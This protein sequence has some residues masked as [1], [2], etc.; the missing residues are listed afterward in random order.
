MSH[1]AGATRR[2]VRRRALGLGLAVLLAGGSLAAC[3]SSS[4]SGGSGSGGD[5]DTGTLTVWQN[6]PMEEGG[7]G[8]MTQ[9]AKQ[10]E[11]AHPGAKIQFVTKPADNY[12]AILRAALIGHTGPDVA[13]IYPGTYVNGLTSNFLNLNPYIPVS[14]RTSIPGV[15]YFSETGDPNTNTYAM[16][17][18]NLFYNMWYN[19][20]LF[21]EAGVDSP[22]TDFVEMAHDCALFNAKGIT[23]YVDGNP[24]F[25]TPYAGAVSDWS[26]LVSAVY[27]LSD[28]NGLTEG[29]IPYNSPALVKEIEQWAGLFNAGCATKS[30][31]TQDANKEFSSGKAAMVMNYNGLY[32]TYSKA[33]GNNLGVMVP[34]WS[35]TPAH[36]LV[37]YPGFGYVASKYTSHPKLA[38]DFIAYTVSQ[39]AQELVAADN[40]LPIN[41]NV[42]ARG[43]ANQDLL[44][45]AEGGKY[46]LYPMF[47]NYMPPEVIAQITSQLPQAF[48]GS[49]SASSAL[50]TM[51]SADKALPSD[52]QHV[53]FH[54]GG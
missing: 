13:E 51:E 33:L 28:L 2:K 23:P 53:N 34:P 24:T 21:A 25:V 7:L 14:V 38:A 49:K 27:S 32:P 48:V 31:L 44:A 30:I 22:P 47:D 35:A 11:A 41:P 26:Y 42:Q 37:E 36:T 40:Q 54:L 45:M 5:G 50:D 15:K 9:V 19:K 6:G 4:S 52:E 17:P 8:F 46:D 3:G 10:F 29:S 12:F 18:V 39:P 1:V 43:K 20:K 16:P